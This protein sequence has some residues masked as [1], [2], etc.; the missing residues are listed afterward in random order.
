MRGSSGLQLVDGHW[1]FFSSLSSHMVLCISRRPAPHA[2][3]Q[4]LMATRYYS[5]AKAV[6]ILDDAG[7][8]ACSREEEDAWLHPNRS[9]IATDSQGA[10]YP[11]VMEHALDDIEIL[12]MI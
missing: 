7:L 3:T 6:N 5:S 8:A 9:L 1:S 4:S 10:Q 12:D 11:L 2:H